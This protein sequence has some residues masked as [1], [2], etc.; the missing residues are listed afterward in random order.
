MTLIL[1]NR[2]VADPLTGIKAFDRR[3]FKKLDLKAN[4]VELETEIIAKLSQAQKYIIEI[5]VEYRPRLKSEGK[6][7][8][9]RDGLCALLNLLK[10]RFFK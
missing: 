5:P 2:F 4:G 3:L 10:M 6:K 1:F 8:T 9:I 7:I